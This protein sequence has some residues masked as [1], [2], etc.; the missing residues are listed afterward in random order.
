MW[1]AFRNSYD[2]LLENPEDAMISTQDVKAMYMSGYTLYFQL[3][4]FIDGLI[5]SLKGKATKPAPSDQPPNPKVR[6]EC[7]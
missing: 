1:E 5:D 3:V 4:A 6:F 7:K 2:G